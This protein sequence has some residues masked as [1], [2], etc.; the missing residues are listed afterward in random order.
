MRKYYLFLCFFI[1]FNLVKAQ[2]KLSI[3]PNYGSQLIPEDNDSLLHDQLKGIDIAFH[4]STAKMTG[5]WIRFFNAKY[6]EYTFVYLDF[7]ELKGFTDP[8][9]SLNFLAKRVNGLGKHY[10]VISSINMQ[11]LALK[12]S[13][14]IY[15]T[16][17]FG[18]SY[19][20]KTYYSD[21]QNFYISSPINFTI[22]FQLQLEQQLSKRWGIIAA[23]KF[24]HTSNGGHKMPNAGINSIGTSIGLSWKLKS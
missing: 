7:E 14:Y 8:T 19:V 17:G 12:N 23:G 22:R 11:L 13:F 15:F 16:P 10:G 4:Q 5:D 1:V 20:T 9:N 3:L 21:P 2:H 24:V 18:L 6:I